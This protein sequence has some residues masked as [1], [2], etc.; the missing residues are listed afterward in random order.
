[1]IITNGNHM[2]IKNHFGKKPM[3][4]KISLKFY[5]KDYLF[6][7]SN[8]L[9]SGKCTSGSNFILS[10]LQNEGGFHGIVFGKRTISK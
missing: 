6:I 5:G 8:I 7:Y 10:I 9:H 1:M 4:L 3:A 2:I